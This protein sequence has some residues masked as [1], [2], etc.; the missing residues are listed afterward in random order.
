MVKGRTSAMPMT[1]T[2]KDRK[3][4]RCCLKRRKK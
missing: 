4:G 1:I 3:K 2:V